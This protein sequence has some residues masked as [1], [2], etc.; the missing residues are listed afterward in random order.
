[1]PRR[2]QRTKVQRLLH[3][4]RH[5][6]VALRRVGP[7]LLLASNSPRRRELLLEAEFD[8]EIFAPSVTERFD[9]DLTLRELTAFNAM[10]KAMTTARLR[11]KHVV[12]AADTLVTIDDHI[13]GKPKDT[14]EAV[15]MLQR[16]S[17]R[18]HEVCT[19]VFICHLAEAKS[20]S[21]HEIS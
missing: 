10:R 8:F 20:T 7:T 12:L 4:R 9:V 21:F 5:N 2:R 13:L 3:R 17:G 1:M 11:P 15:A 14:N 18:A 6:R 19:S 16:L